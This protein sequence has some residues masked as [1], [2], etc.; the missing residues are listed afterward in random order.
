MCG[1]IDKRVVSEW[2]RPVEMRSTVHWAVVERLIWVTGVW[3]SDRRTFL[4]LP[5]EKEDRNSRMLTARN[6]LALI[7]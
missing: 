2:G 7:C 5:V 1:R 3:Y 4:L 6:R